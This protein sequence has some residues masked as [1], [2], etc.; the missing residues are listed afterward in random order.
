MHRRGLRG[1][2]PDVRRREIR[3]GGKRYPFPEYSSPPR[4][5][6][7]MFLGLHE[8][9]HRGRLHL[10]RRHSAPSQPPPDGRYMQCDLPASRR[11]DEGHEDSLQRSLERLPGELAGRWP[12]RLEEGRAARWKADGGC[13]QR[14]RWSC[15]VHLV[16]SEVIGV[17]TTSA[18]VW[19]RHHRA[20]T[21][22]RRAVRESNRPVRERR[23]DALS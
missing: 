21:G 16:G 8:R 14:R 20:G 9:R 5:G 22:S 17:T 23:V 19:G 4:S 12:A 15:A 18:S 3:H 1:P 2:Q 7:G 10:L 13:T 11:N 6:L